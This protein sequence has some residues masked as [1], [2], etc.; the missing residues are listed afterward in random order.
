M[1]QLANRQFA[2]LAAN[3]TAL[4]AWPLGQGPTWW[5]L[6]NGQQVD[7]DLPQCRCIAHQ[8]ERQSALLRLE[9]SLY[10]SQAGGTEDGAQCPLQ[11]TGEAMGQPVLAGIPA[12]E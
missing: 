8:V 6:Q 7:D 12:Q 11:S 3:G 2:C 10:P 9:S 4:K 1:Q 5:R